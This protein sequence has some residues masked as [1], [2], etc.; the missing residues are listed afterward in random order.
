M[1][2]SRITTSLCFAAI[3][4]YQFTSNAIIFILCPRRN[5]YV[6]FARFSKNMAKT[7]VVL[8]A[9]KEEEQ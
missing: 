3:A 2:T 4:T 1:A 6:M 7:F 5:G 8:S 9:R